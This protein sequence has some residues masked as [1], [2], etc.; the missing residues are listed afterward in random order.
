[1]RKPLDITIVAVLFICIGVGSLLY[2]AIRFATDRD[3]PDLAV[4]AASAL[5]AICAGAY[6][7]RGR[8]WARWLC[9]GWL[10]FHV[11]LSLVHSGARLAV[12]AALFLAISLLLFRPA[13][14]GYFR[15][16]RT[17]T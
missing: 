5:L 15:R 3:L 10:A 16:E 11:V 8:D 6:L 2:G 1:M 4:V 12:H 17:D 7:L 13:A 9:A 14:S